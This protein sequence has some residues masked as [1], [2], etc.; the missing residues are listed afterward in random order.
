M[1]GLVEQLR[2]FNRKERFYLVG[3]ALGKPHFELS[4][5]FRKAVEAQALLTIPVDAL[6]AMD[7][8]L[9]WIHAALLI[10][11]GVPGPVW[12]HGIDPMI[13][14]NQEDADLLIAFDDGPLTHL[15]LVEAKGATGWTNKQMKSKSDRLRAIFGRNAERHPG[16]QPHFVL[17]S[18]R[19]PQQL[20]VKTWPSWMKDNERSD[21]PVHWIRLPMPQDLQQITRCDAAGMIG[22]AGTHWKVLTASAGSGAPE[23][24]D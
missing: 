19:R 2:R 4:D 23:V 20:A 21:E 22:K 7:Y 24:A 1:Q 14:G 6:V 3:Q 11:G 13:A 12:A 10:C 9:N 15:I 18:P 5:E 8:H 17:A 16:V